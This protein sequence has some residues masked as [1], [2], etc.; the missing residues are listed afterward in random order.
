MNQAWK[1]QLAGRLQPQLEYMISQY[2]VIFEN[3][4][5]S[6]IE[7]QFITALWAILR[8]GQTDCLFFGKEEFAEEMLSTKPYRFRSV[9][10]APQFKWRTYTSDFYVNGLSIKK[11]LLIEC[12]GHEF[13]ER[14]KEQ[15]AHDRSRDRL[16][17]QD[18]YTILR[19]TGSEIFRNAYGCARQVVDFA[20]EQKR[21][22]A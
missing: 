9:V 14:T 12:D 13:H 3:F 4:V 6:P 1:T 2:E 21:A 7:L 18:G 8:V 20:Q 15:A 16:A 10:I 5:K 11:R 22:R 19:F 17:Q